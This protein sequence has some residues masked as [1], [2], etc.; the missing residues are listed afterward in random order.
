MR[1]NVRPAG[2]QRMAPAPANPGLPLAAPSVMSLQL[3]VVALVELSLLDITGKGARPTMRCNI[4]EKRSNGGR[5]L[6]FSRR[7]ARVHVQSLR[8][9]VGTP[10]VCCTWC[11]TPVENVSL[12][13]LFA[14]SVGK[15]G[16]PVLFEKLMVEPDT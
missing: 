12:P 1:S 15:D 9:G 3:F 5:Q 13:S 8:V 6:A 14:G 10:R 16:S 7:C 4:S 11:V 2:S